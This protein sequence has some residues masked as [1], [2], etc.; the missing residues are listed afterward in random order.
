MLLFSNS[1]S[2]FLIFAR[3]F[4][5][6]E[7]L[8]N[9]SYKTVASTEDLKVAVTDIED[10]CDWVTSRD[11]SIILSK[12]LF[13]ARRFPPLVSSSLRQLLS[14]DLFNFLSNKHG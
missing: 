5:V 13:S 3:V 14:A 10:I 12:C 6:K 2:E 8:D 9:I 4:D 1:G 7:Q 11:F